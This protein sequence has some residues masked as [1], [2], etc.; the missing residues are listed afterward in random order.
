MQRLCKLALAGLI[1]SLTL[2]TGNALAGIASVWDFDGD[3][4]TTYG[5]GGMYYMDEDDAAHD[6]PGIP[7]GDSNYRTGT[8]PGGHAATRTQTSFGSDALGG[9][10]TF[11]KATDTWTGYYVDHSYARGN[12]PTTG[13]LNRY[14][15][16]MDLR[17]P[18]SSFTS[19][20]FMSL[21]Q[22]SSDNA[23]PGDL[24][25]RL[26]TSSSGAIGISTIGYSAAGEIQPDTW[27]RVAYVYDEDGTSNP[28][29]RVARVY[30]D[31]T[32]VHQSSSSFAG[33]GRFRT[34]HTALPGAT[35]MVNPM[36]GFHLAT[37]NNFGENSSGDF[38]SFM[39]VDRP[40]TPL[41]IQQSGSPTAN[42]LL[43]ATS[44]DVPH[45][46]AVNSLSPTHYYRLN[47]PSDDTSNA[48]VVDIGM[49]PVTGQHEGNFPAA[50]A[51][52]NGV[53]MPGFETGNLALS[54]NDA[55]AVNLGSGSNFAADQMSLSIWFKVK[56]PTYGGGGSYADR[57]FLNNNSSDQLGLYA[58]TD[59]TT[60]DDIGLVVSNGTDNA[61]SARLPSS[62]VNLHDGGWHH[63]VVVRHG[64]GT[65]SD[66]NSASRA[67]V[68]LIVDGVDYSSDL[69]QSG[70]GWGN[71]GSDAQIGTRSIGAV[72]NFAGTTDEAAVWLG[73][74][75]SVAEAQ[76][77]YEAARTSDSLPL[78]ASAVLDSDPI[79]YYRF[80]EP[81]GVT[82]GET[83]V[84]WA[85]RDGVSTNVLRDGVVGVS[86]NY[87]NGAPG[88]GANG[89]R[90]SD[91][92]NGRPLNGLNADNSAALFAGYD[93]GVSNSTDM[94][95]IGNNPA[96]MDSEELTYSMLFNTTQDDA[97]VRMMITDPNSLNSFH[98]V[99]SNGRLYVVTGEGP[100]DMPYGS[101]SGT[102]ND[103]EWHHLVAVRDGDLGSGLSL[104]IDGA[105][106]PLTL[107]TGY[108]GEGYSARIGGYSTNAT[109]FVGLMDEVAI[110]NTALT[111]DDAR[112][113]YSALTVPEPTSVLLLAF[114]VFLLPLFARRRKR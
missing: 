22:T 102:Y 83:V 69:V 109:G 81:S 105:A 113:L 35:T 110:W 33:D 95:N 78:Y 96:L 90:P 97:W 70:S 89:A 74:E 80:D 59:G 9:Y 26:N 14:T 15:M 16:M 21:W 101:T 68:S 17:V 106:V 10:M 71:S 4:S 6:P 104:F 76:G 8:P 100:A 39:F 37:S 25:V 43:D 73:R 98:L 38:G 99:M 92:I 61:H 93:S 32:M 44:H 27:H 87:P 72:G 62:V 7:S 103:G 88:F 34:Y 48:T 12:P 63:A 51:G 86:E 50:V 42:G 111:A 112:G 55:G 56:Q 40:M 18:S 41:E 30:V 108:W 1:V 2:A 54:H 19:D 91:G 114:G 60:G 20:N 28:D 23:S 64:D 24:F 65:V 94:V 82:G 47:E 67:N 52:S 77:L 57:I 53:W 85:R 75:L 11:P 5:P 84:N 66:G 36:Q 13:G 45:A 107:A 3:L 49:S 31:G 58:W 46:R 29:G 79:A